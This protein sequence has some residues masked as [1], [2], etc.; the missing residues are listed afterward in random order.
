MSQNIAPDGWCTACKSKQ[1][2]CPIDNWT[3]EPTYPAGTRV[4]AISDFYAGWIGTT[5]RDTE[6]DY[7]IVDFGNGWND[8]EV[9]TP[10]LLPIDADGRIPVEQAACFIRMANAC[11]TSY[12]RHCRLDD[13]VEDRS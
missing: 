2:S 9:Y 13:E 11:T 6:H 10:E 5:V 7:S 4:I 1:P 3:T 8:H 12:G